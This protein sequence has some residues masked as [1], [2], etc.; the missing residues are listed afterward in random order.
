MISGF[1]KI[2]VGLKIKSIYTNIVSMEEAL[3]LM[4]DDIQLLQNAVKYLS[5]S[6]VLEFGKS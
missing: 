2:E 1:I 3:I 6:A 4:S 5:L